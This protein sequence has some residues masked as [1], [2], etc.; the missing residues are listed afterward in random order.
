VGDLEAGKSP[1]YYVS[2]Y[3]FVKEAEFVK[4]KSPP[5]EEPIQKF[6]IVGAVAL[7]LLVIGVSVV[8]YCLCWRW[9]R[10]DEKQW[11]DGLLR[12]PQDGEPEVF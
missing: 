4:E 8:S 10:A 3:T 9:G 6:V 2:G 7:D 11:G 12:S 5:P 1:V